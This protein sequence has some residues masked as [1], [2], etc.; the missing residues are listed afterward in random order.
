MAHYLLFFYIS[1]VPVSCRRQHFHLMLSNASHAH[2]GE[3]AYYDAF[4]W[5]AISKHTHCIID[6]FL[7]RSTPHAAIS[8]AFFPWCTYRRT[9]CRCFRFHYFWY[10]KALRKIPTL[11]GAPSTS[12]FCRERRALPFPYRYWSY[13]L[14]IWFHAINI[15]MKSRFS[16]YCKMPQGIERLCI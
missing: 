16:L 10:T 9:I 14:F 6:I 5:C 7:N 8:H 3:S 13:R 2:R 1:I 4:Y 15:E 12:I 11:F